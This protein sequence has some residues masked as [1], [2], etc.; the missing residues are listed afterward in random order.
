MVTSVSDTTGTTPT[1]AQN[2][3]VSLA[4]NFDMFLKLLTTQLKNQDPT[5]PMDSK[6]FT[7]QLVQFSQVEQAINQNKNLEKLLAAFAAQQSGN[8][9]SYIGKQIDI[10]TNKAAL[11]TS[12]PAVWYYDLPADATAGQ[13]RVIDKNGKIVH[14]AQI[15]KGKGEH[16]FV[17]DGTVSGGQKAPPG[18][19]TLEVVAQDAAANKMDAKIKSRGVVDSIER[20]DGVDYLV[21]GGKKF[22]AKD[23]MSLRSP[24]AI[25]N[26]QE[27]GSYVN[28][29]GKDV[30][31]Y[32]GNTVMQNG[33]ARWSYGMGANSSS[34][35]LKVYDSNNNLVYQTTG[36]TTKGRH[37]FEWDGTKTNGGTAQEGEIYKL[38]V[39]AKNSDNQTVGV[40]VLGRGKVDSVAFENMQAMFSIGGLGVPPSW[41]VAV[42]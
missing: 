13:L 6:E 42:Y 22:E 10:D 41:V 9:V 40:D 7:N 8:L 23:V 3:G 1:A 12:Q 21:V 25:N 2:A 33:D 27:N 37:T 5:S 14:T 28:Y 39:E 34:T 4:K 30:E 19:Y 32:G 26:P 35:V 15:E 29:I 36:S 24:S 31:F 20:I 17:W 18:D 16:T 11:S 38:V